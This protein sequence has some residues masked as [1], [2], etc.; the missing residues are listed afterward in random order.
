VT[1]IV[2][3]Y[4]G[5]IIRKVYNAIGNDREL[6]PAAYPPKLI[7]RISRNNTGHGREVGRFKAFAISSFF[8]LKKVYRLRYITQD[9]LFQDFLKGKS[10]LQNCVFFCGMLRDR[11]KRTPLRFHRE[12]DFGGLQC[13]ADLTRIFLKNILNVEIFD[14][15]N[16]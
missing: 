2:L 15:R 9:L 5:S 8:S 14:Y 3:F 16:I 1:L 13:I 12:R 6:S 11:A 7:R 10:G 4:E